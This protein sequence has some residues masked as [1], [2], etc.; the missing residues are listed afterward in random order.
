VQ[1]PDLDGLGVVHAIGAHRMP[2]VVFVTAY[3]RYA[4]KAFEVNALDYL[5]KPVHRERF[6]A[7]V[8]RARSQ[9]ERGGRGEMSQRLQAL[10]EHLESKQ[11]STRRLMIKSAGR[12]IFLKLDEIDW[13]E[14]A[15]NY[16]VLHVGNKS[17]LLRETMDSLEARIDPDQFVRI[18]RS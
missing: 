8:A 3:D 2:M 7:A 4:V 17:H 18:H 1:M 15:H 5:L 13:I 16:L 10:L 14:A 11:E 9:I 12:V 6:Q